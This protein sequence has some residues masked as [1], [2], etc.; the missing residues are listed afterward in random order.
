MADGKKVSRA[1]GNDLTLAD[2]TA[3]GFDAPTVRYW[4]LATHYRT[5]LRYLH[6]ELDRARQC[7]FRLNE[8]AARLRHHPPGQHSASLDQVLYEARTGWQNAMDND[9]NV[10]MALGNVFTFIRRTN[11]LM[12]HQE[13]DEEQVEQA[14]DF[15]R[16]VNQVLDVIEFEAE[17]QDVKIEEIVAE[18]AQARRDNDFQRADE[19][20]DQLRGMGVELVDGPAGT[21]WRKA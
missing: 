3:Q 15:M 1:A 2:L 19:L 9:L 18:R 10:S 21:R 11:R 7:V 14:L 6:T 8:F 12:N 20:R 4:L 17:T 13:L 16:Q 5:V